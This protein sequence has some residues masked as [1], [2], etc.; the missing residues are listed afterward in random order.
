MLAIRSTFVNWSTRPETLVGVAK[1]M[2]KACFSI[3]YVV[4]MVF[5]PTSRYADQLRHESSKYS[6][7]VPAGPTVSNKPSRLKA[8]NILAISWAILAEFL[9]HQKSTCVRSNQSTNTSGKG[10]DTL[11]YAWKSTARCS[12]SGD[13]VVWTLS[14]LRLTLTRFVAAGVP[15]PSVLVPLDSPGLADLD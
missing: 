6:D 2:N 14:E 12:M 4:F 15:E 10:M 5:T 3:T 1:C 11:S 13:L 9:S 8:N 7:D